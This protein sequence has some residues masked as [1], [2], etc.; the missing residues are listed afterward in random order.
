MNPIL[1]N[2]SRRFQE[3][4]VKTNRK[5]SKYGMKVHYLAMIVIGD[6]YRYAHDIAN[7]KQLIA[8]RELFNAFYRHTMGQIRVHDYSTPD[9]PHT[10]E[11][12]GCPAYCC[13]LGYIYATPDEQRRIADHL[14]LP[15][16]DIFDQNVIIKPADIA[17]CPFLDTDSRCQIYEVRPRLCRIF[18]CRDSEGM[19]AMRKFLEDKC[20]SAK[21]A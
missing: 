16:T 11:C 5:L 6:D 17:P 15:I 20:T 18:H 10:S 7:Q 19:W 14:S 8:M 1:N 4:V 12:D 2:F 3:L 9:A 13:M 21:T